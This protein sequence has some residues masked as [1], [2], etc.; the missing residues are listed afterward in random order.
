MTN[1]ASDTEISFT[2][3]TLQLYEYAFELKPE[4]K[5]IQFNVNLR[6]I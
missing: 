5:T 2:L 1:K 3:P 4:R 6:E